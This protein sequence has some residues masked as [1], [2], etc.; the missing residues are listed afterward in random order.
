MNCEHIDEVSNGTTSGTIVFNNICNLQ[1]KNIDFTDFINFNHPIALFHISEETKNNLKRKLNKDKPDKYFYIV[2]DL[3]KSNFSDV[4]D[5]DGNPI[6]VINM[7]IGN[8]NIDSNENIF[9]VKLTI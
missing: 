4:F 7:Y 2:T 3:D 1:N 5:K 9:Y 8:P 6:T